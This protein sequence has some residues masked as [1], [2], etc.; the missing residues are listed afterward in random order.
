MFVVSKVKLFAMKRIRIL[1][2]VL[3]IAVVTIMASCRSSREYS[4]YPP[5]RPQSNFSLIISSYPGPVSRD[6]YGRYYY[7]DPYGHVY[8][9]GYDNR[10]YLD[11]RYVSRS[12]YRHQQYNDWRRY[13]NYGRH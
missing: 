10:F 9:R 12:Y 3:L 2:A 7:R 11:K 4:S 8:W 5:P 1:P 6:L 13:H